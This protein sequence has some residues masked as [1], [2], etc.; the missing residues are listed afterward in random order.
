MKKLLGVM[1]A[2]VMALVMIWGCKPREAPPAEEGLP[3]INAVRWLNTE[4]NPVTLAGLRG[5]VVVVEFWATWCPPCRASIPHLV[6]LHNKYKDEGVV[7]IGLTDEDYDRA[8]IGEFMQ[9]MNMTYIVGTGSTSG[10]DYGV[11]GI[12]HAVVIGKDGRQVW[13]GHPMGK[14]EAAIEVALGRRPAVEEAGD[15]E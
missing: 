3:E 7:I 10:R 14:L 12:P 11:R 5:K 8:K 4:M 6:E 13:K 2:S 9:Q 1:S 15:N